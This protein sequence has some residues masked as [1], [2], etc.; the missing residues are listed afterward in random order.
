[1]IF[2]VIPTY[3]LEHDLVSVVECT[4][5]SQNV[6]L[7]R[8]ECIKNSPNNS[9]IIQHVLLTKAVV[10]VIFLKT[11]SACKLTFYM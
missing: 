9:S 4:D 5:V 1:M 7:R 10:N 8:S 3:F 2:Y 11:E 6:F